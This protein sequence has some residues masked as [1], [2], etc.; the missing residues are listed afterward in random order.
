MEKNKR[1]ISAKINSLG[2]KTLNNTMQKIDNFL[3][4]EII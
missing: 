1:E 2:I 4:N 3:V